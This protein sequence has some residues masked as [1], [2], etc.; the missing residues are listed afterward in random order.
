MAG[1]QG[2]LIRPAAISLDRLWLRL[3]RGL[4][5][6]FLALI[7]AAHANEA[8]PIRRERPPP[9]RSTSGADTQAGQRLGLLSPT[10]KLSAPEPKKE[11]PAYP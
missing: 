3:V 9:R 10:Q 7:T 1:S 5:L 4:A 8:A 6:R 2:R 11:T